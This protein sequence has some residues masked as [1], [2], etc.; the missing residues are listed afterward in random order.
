MDDLTYSLL[1]NKI[2]KENIKIKNKLIKILEKKEEYSYYYIDE[3]Y[4]TI[5]EFNKN[6]SI[7][8]F[9]EIYY[10][11]NNNKNKV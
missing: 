6:N 7:K 3:L 4:E 10:N 9:V 2:E 11:N 1:V 8:D 5:K